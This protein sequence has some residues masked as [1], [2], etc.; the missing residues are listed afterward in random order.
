[1]SADAFLSNPKAKLLL[2]RKVAAKPA[3]TTADD[4]PA[5]GPTLTLAEAKKAFGEGSKAPAS[6]PKR[7]AGQ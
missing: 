2:G 5:D 7:K 6:T 4:T 3:Q 1:M